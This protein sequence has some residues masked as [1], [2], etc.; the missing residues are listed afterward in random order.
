V[1]EFRKNT[2]ETSEGG[3]CDER[4]AK[5]GYHFTEGDD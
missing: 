4:I 2:G 3:S 5:K 1:V